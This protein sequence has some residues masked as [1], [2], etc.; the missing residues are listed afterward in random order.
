MDSFP[1]ISAY[2]QTLKN[3]ADQLANVN[4]PVSKKR[5][6]LQLVKGLNSKYNTVA[7]IIQQTTP[8][9][10]F[11]KAHS[12]LTM[13]GSRQAEM[14]T[15]PHKAALTAV[16]HNPQA[17]TQVHIPPTTKQSQPSD[18]DSN[19]HTTNYVP[20]GGGRGGRSRGR[21]GRSRGRGSTPPPWY[22]P[23][24]YPP[25]WH[26]PPVP[27][28]TTPMARGRGTPSSF[29]GILGAT[30]QQYHASYAPTN[31]AH[32]FAG[33]QLDPD[34]KWYMDTGATS[35]VTHNLGNL[36]S[37]YVKIALNKILLLAMDPQFPFMPPDIILY[38]LL[39]HL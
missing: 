11:Y 35:H 4:S 6:V 1:D 28:P 25:T 9:P 34:H 10:D 12:M 5:L 24:Q 18:P 21:G 2:C 36:S 8:L 39:T 19:Q 3:I 20:R 29:A 38:H 31:L 32:T 17:N 16:A 15:D 14:T 30:P 37:S 33:L 7:S 23:W 22:S 13:E 27:Y 26:T